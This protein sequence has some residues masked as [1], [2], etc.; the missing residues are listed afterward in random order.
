MRTWPRAEGV[1]QWKSIYSCSVCSIHETL[2]LI[3]EEEEKE[4]KERKKGRRKEKGNK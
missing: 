3:K 4:R 1:T 2:A